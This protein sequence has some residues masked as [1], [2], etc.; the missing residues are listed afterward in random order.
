[1]E[2]GEE[3]IRDLE[4]RIRVF[5]VCLVGVLEGDKID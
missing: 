5:S 1:M 2:K 4:D 3:S